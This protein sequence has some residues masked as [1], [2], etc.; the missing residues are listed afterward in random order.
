M[1]SLEQSLMNELAVPRTVRHLLA[2]SDMSVLDDDQR[3]LVRTRFEGRAHPLLQDA[4]WEAL[5]PYSPLLLA[6][7][8]ATETG[9]QRLLE[10]FHGEQGNL[11]HGWITSALPAEQLAAHLAQ[12]I[13][14]RGPQGDTFLL[15]YYDPFVLPVLYR[16]ADPRWWAELMDPIASWWIPRADTKVQR[17]GRVTGRAATGATAPSALVIDDTLW[18]A[19]IAD[20]LPHQLLQATQNHTPALF[21]TTCPGVRLAR[22][23][24]HLAAAREAGL[25]AHD[26][27][28]DYVFFALAQPASSLKIDRSWQQAVRA[29]ASGAGRLGDLYL[30]L[31]QRQV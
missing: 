3:E 4:T 29:A 17:W 9:H 23:E 20:P 16:H 14:A 21:D 18:Q 25:S 7:Q 12:A 27:L 28:H 26:D 13:V 31:R 10:S 2:V 30:A 24:A 1:K 5:L 11:L 8:E 19:L 6:A 15:R 22:I